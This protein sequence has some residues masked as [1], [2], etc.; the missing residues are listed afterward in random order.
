MAYSHYWTRIQVLTRIR[1][2]TPTATLFCTEHVHIA[3]IWTQ[4]L[5][6][7]QIPD[8]TVPIF[9]MDICTRI[10]HPSPCSAM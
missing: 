8:V 4:I 5:I 7:T 1:I 9:G 2:P 10:G 3:Q 6:Q